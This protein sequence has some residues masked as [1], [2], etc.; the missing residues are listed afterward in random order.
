MVQLLIAD[1]I[2]FIESDFCLNQGIGQTKV[3]SLQFV[4]DRSEV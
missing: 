4:S 2:K 3:G 1:S